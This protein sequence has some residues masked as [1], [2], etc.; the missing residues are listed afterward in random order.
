M[1]DL[2]EQNAKWVNI[3]ELHGKVKKGATRGEVEKEQDQQKKS[4]KRENERH[5]EEKK[6]QQ[7][8]RSRL[9]V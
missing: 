9:E 6:T 1:R 2:R 8:V 3:G 7:M 5:T 4:K